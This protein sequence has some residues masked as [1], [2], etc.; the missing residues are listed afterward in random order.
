MSNKGWIKL[1]RQIM[2]S[3]IWN[4]EPFTYG[5]AWI[6]LL[7]L[8]NHTTKKQFYDGK[9]MTFKKGTVCMSMKELGNRWKWDRRK[10]KNFLKLLESDEMLSLKCTTHGTTI[11][12][13]NYGKFQ[14]QG[15]TDSTT[16][17]QQDVQPHDNDMYNDMTTTCT[18]TPHKQE[19]KNIKNEKELKE[20]KELNNRVASY[21]DNPDLDLTIYDFINY[22]KEMKK[23]MS[24]IA[25]HKLLNRLDSLADDDETKIEILNQSMANSWIGIFP[26][27]EKKQNKKEID[28]EKV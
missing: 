16:D 10:V 3:W 7:L 1:D 12:L 27:G 24:D 17:A 2:D 5:Q 6:D 19:L 21:S 20:L 22:R 11:T 8:A 26:L 13:V 18:T 9:L 4:K 23:P 25:I 15:T 28:W 14:S